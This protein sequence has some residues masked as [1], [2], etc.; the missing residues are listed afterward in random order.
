MFND[1]NANGLKDGGESGQSGWTVYLDADGNGQL[2][3]GETSAITAADGSYSFTGLAAGTYTVAEVQ[4]LGWQQTSPVGS[5]P[6]IERV[7]VDDNGVQGNDVSASYGISADGR[8][9]AFFSVASNLVPGDTNGVRDVFV[10]DRQT[11]TTQ[12]VSVASSG[13][14]GNG[15]S[16]APKISADGRYVTFQSDASNLVP[17]DTN[18]MTD[19]FVY[20]RQLNTTE[21]VSLAVDGTTGY[22]KS[23]VGGISADGRYV[24]FSS[25]ANNLVLNDAN[26]MSDVFVFDRQT[27]TMER[28]GDGIVAVQP[29]IS[30]DGRYVSFSSGDVFVYDRDNH[31]FERVSLASDGTQANG[32]SQGGKISADGRYV[33]F[34]SLATNLVPGDTNGTSDNF[35]YDRQTHTTERVSLASDGT[36]TNMT[37]FAGS[38]SADGRYVAFHSMATNLVPG[39]HQ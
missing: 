34:L 24:A 28:V 16:N 21:C 12:R 31:L 30:A 4:Q 26:G 22:G 19:V 27:H 18:G 20:D 39:V 15:A 25:D 13:A 17:G 6:S 8:F 23:S 11:D 5:V 35:V 1:L 38:I 7:S 32:E 36:Q 37:S 14:Q 9:V 10:Y 29:D 33:T 2:G 3:T